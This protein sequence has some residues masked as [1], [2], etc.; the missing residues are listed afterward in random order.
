MTVISIDPAVTSTATRPSL[1]VSSVLPPTITCAPPTG[2]PSAVTV[3]CSV[4]VAACSASAAINAN[5]LTHTSRASCDGEVVLEGTRLRGSGRVIECQM[6]RWWRYA[7]ATDG[8][9]DRGDPE[10]DGRLWLND[11]ARLTERTVGRRL[12]PTGE[13]DVPAA[14]AV[15]AAQRIGGGDHREKHEQRRADPSH[16]V[17][18]RTA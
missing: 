1:P 6:K 8:R 3:T 9:H 4:A 13:P 12:R 14:A 17:Q 7:I 10:R 2:R 15:G 11:H 16:R 5:V 18:Y